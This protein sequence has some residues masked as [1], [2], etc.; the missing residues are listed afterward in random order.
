M[1]TVVVELAG[2]DY[3]KNAV[4]AARKLKVGSVG[5]LRVLVGTL[6]P[7]SPNIKAAVL[8]LKKYL[9]PNAGVYFITS[10][11]S[12]WTA[13]P[14]VTSGDPNSIT[15]FVLDTV[16]FQTSRAVMTQIQSQDQNAQMKNWQNLRDTQ[17]K[18]FQ[19]QQDVTQNKAKTMDKAFQNWDAYI[20][21]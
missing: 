13:G 16:D 9:T 4:E 5:E 14:A 7:D 15:T 17:A 6:S 1:A 11:S 21:G 8:S 3:V 12:S 19:I 2:P 18:I 10:G 20:R